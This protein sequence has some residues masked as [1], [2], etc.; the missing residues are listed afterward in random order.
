MV[1]VGLLIMTLTSMFNSRMREM[2]RYAGN[3]EDVMHKQ[4]RALSTLGGPAFEFDMRALAARPIREDEQ[5]DKW[6]LDRILIPE[7]VSEIVD[8]RDEAAY[9]KLCDALLS[10]RGKVSGDL[11]L[12]REPGA[13]AR[14]YRLTLSEPEY[15]G[16]NMAA[17]ATLVDIDDVAQRMDALR[18]RA[19]CDEVTGLCTASELRIKAGRLLNRPNHHFGTLAFIRSDNQDAVCDACPG[20]TQDELMRMCAGLVRE[21]FGECDVFARGA[22]DEFWVFSGDQTGVEIIQKGMNKIMDSA[23]GGDV[24]LTF[25]CGIAHADPD[26]D[27]DSLIKRAYSAAQMAHRDGGR[28]LQHG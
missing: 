9:L 2:R 21:A 8:P 27:M 13:P 28:R 16:D 3:I 5:A 23:L 18:Q 20:L 7:C 14:M 6:L 26:D 15:S 1:I 10:A 25:S 11:R 12:R 17:I 22:G 4:R 19:A 24:H